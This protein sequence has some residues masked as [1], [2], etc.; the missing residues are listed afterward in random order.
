MSR[1]SVFSSVNLSLCHLVHRDADLFS[2][3]SDTFATTSTSASSVR[4]DRVQSRSVRP[5][6]HLVLVGRVASKLP[7]SRPHTVSRLRSSRTG[8]TLK[9]SSLLKGFG[10]PPG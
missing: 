6:F 10:L 1:V 5:V 4:L 7:L 8:S 9:F 3:R 2:N